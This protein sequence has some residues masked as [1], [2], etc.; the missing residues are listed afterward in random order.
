MSN[1][2]K[3][4]N[5]KKQSNL[6]KTSNETFG[7]DMV[8]DMG[9]VGGLLDN[10]INSISLKQMFMYIG[11]S[12][13]ALYLFSVSYT[14]LLGTNTLYSTNDIVLSFMAT[15][16]FV[17]WACLRLPKIDGKEGSILYI[18]IF[19]ILYTMIIFGN[20]AHIITEWTI[21]SIVLVEFFYFMDSKVLKII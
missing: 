9:Y 16:I 18:I 3:N 12:G 17:L 5:S 10:K 11:V 8:K 6:N 13:L 20:N 19:F 7:Q 1:N 4:N 2:K 21:I 14:L 15:F